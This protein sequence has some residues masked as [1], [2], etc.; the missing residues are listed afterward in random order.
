MENE[1][2]EPALKYNYTYA[3]E[4]LEMERASSEKHELHQGTVITMT[5][6]SLKHNQI[7]SNLLGNLHPFLKGKSCQVFSSDLRTKI[8]ATDTFTY[9]D[10]SIV[11]GEPELMDEQFDTILNPSIIIEVLSPSTEK[12]DKGNKFFYYMQ[13]Q[14][15]TEYFMISSMETYIHVARKQNDSSWKFEEIKD[16]A[17]SLLISTIQYNI[18]LSDIYYNVKF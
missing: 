18:P 16:V 10:L 6:A 13:I 11:C 9:P 14:S 2:K 15:L 8:P 1:V 17:A 12:Y 5:G 4:Y 7:V 3:A